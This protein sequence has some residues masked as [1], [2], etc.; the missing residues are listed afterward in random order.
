MFAYGEEPADVLHRDGVPAVRRG[1]VRARAAVQDRDGA[2]FFVTNES[3]QGCTGTGPDCIGGKSD[4]NDDGRIGTVLQILRRRRRRRVFDRDDDCRNARTPT[5][6]TPTATGRRRVRSVPTCVPFAPAPPPV[7]PAGAAACQKAIGS[8]SRTLLKVHLS[9][10]RKCLDQ[11]AGGKLSGDANLL[12]RG[13]LPSLEPTDP[14]TAAKIAKARLKLQA[15]LAGK[16][17]D[18]ILNQLA[19]CGETASDLSECISVTVT[20]IAE[21]V[22]TLLY[23]DVA[24]ITDAPALACQKALGKAAATETASFAKA[25]DG[26]LDKVNTG[27]LSGNSQA[28]CLGAWASAGPVPQGDFHTAERVDK[29]AAKAASAIQAK[30]P[31]AALAPLRACGG[32]T[33]AGVAACIRCAAFT[34][35]AGLVDAAY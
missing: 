13:A 14:T 8:A 16:C 25:M 9:A 12:C 26:C 30:C 7:A 5:S 4:L 24:A 18:A 33:A 10:Q 35:V 1:R 6:S 19:A 21:T 15:T 2:I 29:A 28:M 32:G 27:D 22:T 3:D 17:S 11:V 20:G 23:G 31:A 34:Q